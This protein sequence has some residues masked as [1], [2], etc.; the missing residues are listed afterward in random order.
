MCVVIKELLKG[1]SV[2][3]LDNSMKTDF[4]FKLLAVS[5]AACRV[6]SVCM[7]EWSWNELFAVLCLEVLKDML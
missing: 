5:V 4:L 3:E 1:I 2:I 7:S 6:S